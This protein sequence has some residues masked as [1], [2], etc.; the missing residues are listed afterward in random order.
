M[1]MPGC[2]DWAR[3]T[4]SIASTRMELMQSS[5]VRSR[6]DSGGRSGPVAGALFVLTFSVT[7]SFGSL[8]VCCDAIGHRRALQPAAQRMVENH[9]TTKLQNDDDGGAARN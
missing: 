7:G 6:N 4:A 2:P 5:S 3:S 8:C 9:S 1:G